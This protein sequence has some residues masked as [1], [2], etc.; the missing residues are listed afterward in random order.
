VRGAWTH[1]GYLRVRGGHNGRLASARG[2]PPSG[3]ALDGLRDRPTS[4]SAGVGRSLTSRHLAGSTRWLES[5]LTT[6]SLRSS[7][8]AKPRSVARSLRGVE[9]DGYVYFSLKETL[10]V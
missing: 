8:A 7:P 9:T 2:N 5:A 1:T 4:V 6:L 3:R 10:E